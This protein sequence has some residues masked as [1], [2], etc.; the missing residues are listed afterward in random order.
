M[1]SSDQIVALDERPELQPAWLGARLSELVSI[2]SVTGQ[3]PERA[4]VAHIQSL[5]DGIGAE[6]TS[7]EVE[8]G[9]P[10]LAAV[11]P[12]SGEGPRL[13]LNGHM[14]TV[15]PDDP[16]LWSVDPFG[17]EE[18]EGAIWGRGS[19]DMKG[20]LVTQIACA[21]ALAAVPERKGTLVL[22]FAMG[23][24]TGEPGTLA[25]LEAGFGGDFGITT[26]PTNLEVAIAQRGCATFRLRL[27][28][29]SAHAASPEAGRNPIRALPDLLIALDAYNER[30]AEKS[31]PL[32]GSVTATPTTLH[33]GVQHNAVADLL[34]LIVDRRLLPGETRDAALAEL[35]ELVSSALDPGL[36]LEWDLEPNG[37]HYF[38]P[39]EIPE[40]SPF[41]A[42]V[43]SQVEA[44]TGTRPPYIGTAYGSDVRNL[45]NDAGIE[46]VTFGPGRVEDCHCPDEHL[47]LSD[48]RQAALVVTRVAHDILV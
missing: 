40:D 8:P 19:V 37:N 4:I 10:S 12:G 30:L 28:G 45:V 9:R 32:F 23:E 47:A 36:G 1:S 39:A 13:V 43:L 21:R 5:L 11:L 41:A 33:A 35:W 14:D 20:G 24:E 38:Q 6:T 48:L 7:I 31:H 26:E 46:A 25:L 17:G 44:V 42:R 27:H 16:E 34:T 3:D 2:P 22:H 18:R 15:P 29:L